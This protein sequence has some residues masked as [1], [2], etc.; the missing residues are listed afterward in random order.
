MPGEQIARPSRSAVCRADRAGSHIAR[1]NP[2]EP[3]GNQGWK[4]MMSQGKQH[5][6][7][8]GWFKVIRADYC[9]R[10]KDNRI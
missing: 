6:T 1:V 10:V 7:N 4:A 9:G 2:I 5:L 3:A 8:M